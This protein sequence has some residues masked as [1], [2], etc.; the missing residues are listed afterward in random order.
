ML[1]QRSMS[2]VAK[3]ITNKITLLNSKWALAPNSKSNTPVSVLFMP[4]LG[5]KPRHHQQYIKLYEDVYRPLRKPVDILVVQA[6]LLDFIAAS[7]GKKLSSDIRQVVEET[8]SPSSKIIAH[9]MSVGNFIHAVNLHYDENKFFQEKLAG[10][11][12]DSPVYG[13]PIKSGGL[14]RI[15]EGIVGTFLLN[16]KLDNPLTRR[17]LMSAAKITVKPNTQLFDDY[18]TTFISK[19][20]CAPILTF[21]STNDVMMDSVKY[22]V[23]VKDWKE[24]GVNVNDMCFPK[25]VHAQHIIQH[26]SV[27]KTHFTKF[28]STLQL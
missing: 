24:R 4:F 15:I 3:K 18:I 13:G 20:G 27:F 28:L 1:F 22:D 19:S 2:F 7:K 14:E 12:F 9:G 5:S 8:F 21:Y 17:M 16:S 23:V 26:P 6:N 11:I 10:Q 25:S